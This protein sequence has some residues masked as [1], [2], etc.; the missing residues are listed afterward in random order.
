MANS[1]PFQTLLC[2][3]YSD[4]CFCRSYKSTYI[5]CFSSLW[6]T[7]IS[8]MTFLWRSLFSICISLKNVCLKWVKKVGQSWTIEIMSLTLYLKIIKKMYMDWKWQF[9][10]PS[11]LL[12]KITNRI[13]YRKKEIKETWSVHLCFCQKILLFIIIYFFSTVR[14]QHLG[15]HSL[16]YIITSKY[17]WKCIGVYLF[18]FKIK[19]TL[20]ILNW[21]HIYWPGGWCKLSVW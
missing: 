9:Q 8:W 21:W 5:F 12:S 15:Q 6:R 1:I 3:F 7:S 10:V 18:F 17:T 2:T 4:I 19:F 11:Y 16:S 13:P 20:E 14:K